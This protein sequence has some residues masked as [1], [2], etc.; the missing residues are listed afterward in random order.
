MAEELTCGQAKWIQSAE[1]T[2]QADG[3]YHVTIKDLKNDNNNVYLINII[4][5]VC[6]GA[7]ALTPCQARNKD[8]GEQVPYEMLTVQNETP[9]YGT[10]AV[11]LRAAR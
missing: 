5:R 1:L 10:S 7:A 8:T 6:L 4:V 11:P 3:R 2:V 9:I